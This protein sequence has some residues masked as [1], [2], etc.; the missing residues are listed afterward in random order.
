MNQ[1]SVKQKA[2]TVCRVLRRVRLLILVII[3][4]LFASFGLLLSP[5]FAQSLPQSFAQNTTDT[6]APTA[7]VVVDGRVL[8]R[9]GSVDG[10]A[11]ER[12]AN[13]VNRDLQTAIET[14]PLDQLIRINIAEQDALTTIR[15]NNR[16]LLTV[17]DSDFMRGVTHQEQA[18][19]WA[20]LLRTALARAQAERLPSYSRTAIWRSLIGLGIAIALHILIRWFRSRLW[21]RWAS[22]P[23][24]LAYSRRLL[25]PMLLCLRGALWLAFLHYLCSLWPTARTTRYQTFQFL[26]R[27]FNNDILTLGEQAYSLLDIFQLILF[28]IALWIGVRGLTAAI[29]SRF[30]QAAIPDRSIQE[31]I[32][33]LTQFLLMALGLFISL[34]AWGIDLSALAIFASVLGVGVGF[35]LQDIVNNFISGWILLIER[36]VQAGDFIHVGDLVGTVER[37]GAR[38]T[39]LRTPDRISILVPNAELVQNRVV[40]WSH[41]RSVSRLH[42]PLGVAYHS[43]IDRVHTA[44]I[45]AAQT[46]P[47]VLRYPEPRLRFLG[48]GESSLDFDLLIW[49]RD[50]R[51]QYDIK[52]DVYYLVEAN[53]RRYQIEIPFPQRDI[54]LRP[55]Q[56]QALIESQ[57]APTSTA[58]NDN[59]ARHTA[60]ERTDPTQQINAHISAAQPPAT[61]VRTRQPGLKKQLLSD[62]TAYSAILQAPKNLSTDEVTRL[63]EQMRGPDGIDIGD[64]RFWLTVYPNS[65][66]GSEAVTWIVKTQK[67]TREAAVRLGQRLVENGLIHHVT[68]EHPFKDEYLFYRFYEDES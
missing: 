26:N 36:P 39:E 42:L 67:A 21:R 14:T 44:V 13:S 15:L 54:N 46:H 33:T 37:V 30:L 38:S 59:H 53:L 56:L 40:N 18:E 11:A 10:F 34:Q 45:E 61:A 62:I 23:K 17:T 47:Y 27:S 35:G 58:A 1:D 51:Q 29:K 8:F 20:P 50:P 25:M 2:V 12:R 32:A 41:G 22:R 43:P 64:H 60:A 6:P 66:V 3:L 68:D 49:I 4:S 7:D 48:F 5:S 31:V 28:I 57:A 55:H 16:H 52:S 9:L 19:E 65:F 24:R 63:Y